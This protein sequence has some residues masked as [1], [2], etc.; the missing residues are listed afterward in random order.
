MLGALGAIGQAGA[1]GQ[2]GALGIGGVGIG[3][4]VFPIVP[5][6][7]RPRTNTPGAAM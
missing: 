7:W 4:G 6:N 3:G 5:G 1:L 2:L